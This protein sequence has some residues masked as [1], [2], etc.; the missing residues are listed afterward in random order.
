MARHP[1]FFVLGA[2]AGLALWLVEA[3]TPFPFLGLTSLVCGALG[4]ALSIAYIASFEPWRLRTGVA[5]LRRAGRW[6]GRTFGAL[7]GDSAP[8]ACR[9]D[10][11]AL[12]ARSS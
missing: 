3:P 6:V 9:A 10:V 8:P 2:L 7:A 1:S 5:S 11:T 4:F 12:R